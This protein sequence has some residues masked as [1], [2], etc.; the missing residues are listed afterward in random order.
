MEENQVQKTGT[1]E[2]DEGKACAVILYVVWLAGILW[3]F[4][5]EKGMRKNKFAKYHAEQSIM[6]LVASTIFSFVFTFFYVFLIFIPIIG[7][8]LMI[9][10]TLG[11]FAPLV[12][13]IIGIVYAA[14]G[15]MKPL[16]IIGKWAEKWFNF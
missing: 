1:K 12:W 4:L 13:T 6:L 9:P 15:E 14:K 7:W 2:I 11:F 8:L 5:D 3:F 10:M 16:P